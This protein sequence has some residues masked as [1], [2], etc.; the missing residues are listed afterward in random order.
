MVK[1][2]QL[3]QATFEARAAYRELLRK[4]AE[5]GFADGTQ[6]DKLRADVERAEKL[7]DELARE[8]LAEEMR[9][10][11][12]DARLVARREGLSVDTPGDVASVN[13]LPALPSRTRAALVKL[14]PQASGDAEK[15]EQDWRGVVAAALGGAPLHPAILAATATEGVPSDGGFLV[16]VEVA[17]G[18][19]ARAVEESVWLR[20]GARLEP[21]NSET[22]IINAL[23]DYDESEDAEATL[24]ADWQAE[25]T[26]ATA[27]VMK[28][29]RVEL[30]AR[31]LVV[32]AAASNELAED[33]PGYIDALQGA[34]SRAI[35]KKFD[36]AVLVGTGAAMP[37]GVLN[38]PATVTV[39]KEAGQAAD[40]LEW[41]NIVGMWARLAPGSHERAFWLMHPT[42]LPEALSMSLVIGVGGTQ[43]RG[44]FE[45]GGPTGYQLLG[46]P[47]V[48]TSRVKPLGD[49]G[50]VILVDP[51]Q[52]AVGVRRQL[53]IERSE[54]A[55]FSSDRL[56]IRGKFRGD[57]R[58]LWESTRTLVD[59]S[60]TVGPVVVL[61][62]R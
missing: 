52:I 32:L 54:Q 44:V 62:A 20:I 58:P 38:S 46:R 24:K 36:R 17:S 11:E 15:R 41:E 50:D 2:N 28:L 10:S 18:V 39:S 22:K 37:L 9:L 55:F 33:A 47:V 6:G 56:A 23:D 16:T 48:V 12:E 7:V 51:T 61:E 42:C 13:G 35:A 3:R 45:S 27:Q 30:H 5:G 40:T 49:L 53:T 14:F 34:L 8:T 29:R 19:F 1:V 4:Q 25:A 21:M 60:T 59:G 26:E 31:K 57:A 43:P